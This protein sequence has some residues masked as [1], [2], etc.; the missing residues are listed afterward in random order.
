MQR[1]L[2]LEPFL[3]LAVMALAAALRFYALDHS[4]LWSDEGNTWALVQRSFA[5]I[6]RDAAADIHPPG[7]Y[8]LLKLWTMLLG[9]SAWALRSFSAMAGVL[10][11]G[12]VVA[13]ARQFRSLRHRRVRFPVLAAL[14]AA[15][16][17]FQ[18]YYSQEAR[19]YML[20]AFE[21]AIVL[22]A[23]VA[24]ARQGLDDARPHTRRTA[25]IAFVAAAAAGLWT[26]YSFPVVLAATGLGYVWAWVKTRKR[27][28]P[29]Q[30]RPFVV[31]NLAALVLFL[32]W[33]PTAVT[34]VLNWPKGGAEIA[35]WDGLQRTLQMLMFGPLRHLPAPL[36]PWL[37]A[38]AVVPLIGAAAL[39]RQRGSQAVMLLL[40]LPVLLMF[41]LGLFSDAF[42]KF[43][44][45][46]S[47][48]WCLLV[49]AAPHMVSL[50]R[51]PDDLSARA[52][53][54]VVTFALQAM[55][56][57]GAILIT[58]MVLPGYYAA[59][60][61]RDNYKGVA[62][63]VAAVADPAHDLV[64]LDAPGQAE[65][66][67]YYDPGVPVLAL[68]ETRPP[69]AAATESTLAQTTAAAHNVFALFWATD[70][71]D[72]A[73][74]VE[75]WLDRHGFK[76]LESW[77][78][79]LRFAVYTLQGD[80]ACDPS[81]SAR[82]GNAVA[83][84]RVCTTAAADVD[85]GETLLT[86]LQWQTE[87]PLTRAYNVSVQLL[88]AASQVVAQQDGVPA[89]GSSPTTAWQ[90]G[91]PVVDRHAVVVPFGTP[92]A[93]YRLAVALYD[94]ATGARLPVADG[95]DADAGLLTVGTVTVGRHDG[96]VPI[97]IVPMQHRLQ[98]AMGPLT[99]LGYDMY[100]QGFAH[101][102]DTPPAP[103]DAVQFVLY[104]QAPVWEGAPPADW[105]ADV[106]L[107]LTLG[108]TQVG[109]PLAAGYPTSA[110]QAGDLVRTLVT[111]PYDGS[112]PRPVLQVDDE[113]VVLRPLPR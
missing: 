108:D 19:M 57:L 20:L 89:G 15:V 22:W 85:Q 16:N 88:D 60:D 31:L 101:A 90:P 10:V 58:G 46:A 45:V 102:P 105:P 94:P 84:T 26:H 13:M 106:S 82:F 68:P 5:Q 35:F 3:I 61:A 65:V 81:A 112:D 17:P 99:L 32:P 71:A 83:L 27:E 50:E 21:A 33:L 69:D 104:W 36:W 74:V 44:L 96:E 41:G 103:G 38:A 55:I 111:V 11:V 98:R 91:A 42:M 43:L 1:R 97:A 23:T 76:G 67:R 75:G 53:S 4:S 6:A 86:E 78:G 62:A 25:R 49:A 37:V 80:L 34:S 28:N 12:V 8:W 73:G 93:R 100:K 72:P 66:W 77:Q 92:P 24:L 63:Y 51:A 9:T 56:A 70:E 113:R 64:V 107:Q 59:P 110:W 79:N 52:D 14:I 87:A 2:R 54:D 18:I 47:P 40:L 48:A 109:A 95:G 7:Y 30:L 39:W 29:L